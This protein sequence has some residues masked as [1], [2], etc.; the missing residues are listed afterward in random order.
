MI[1][2][3]IIMFIFQKRLLDLRRNFVRLI[4]HEIRTPLNSLS[5]GLKLIRTGLAEGDNEQEINETIDQVEEACGVAVEVLNGI[6]SYEKIDSGV[7]ALEKER[8]N[9]YGFLCESMKMFVM[10][11]RDGH[12]HISLLYSLSIHSYIRLAR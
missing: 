6:L 8:V 4:S 1:F 10:Q 2:Q 12:L 7:L 3:P 5:M 11:V 9:A